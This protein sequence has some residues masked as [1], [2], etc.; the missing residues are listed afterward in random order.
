[1]KT[2]FMSISYVAILVASLTTQA[3]EA[4]PFQA[5]ADEHARQATA[6]A[7]QLLRSELSAALARIE[8]SG[9]DTGAKGQIAANAPRRGMQEGEAVAQSR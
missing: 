3:G 1:M 4:R 7:R 9:A 6:A 5:V 8:V 2:L